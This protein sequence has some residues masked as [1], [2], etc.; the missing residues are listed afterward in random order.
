MRVGQRAGLK[1]DEHGT[2]LPGP[3]GNLFTV[4]SCNQTG[5]LVFVSVTSISHIN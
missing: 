4:S 2:D 3:E 5:R 1:G